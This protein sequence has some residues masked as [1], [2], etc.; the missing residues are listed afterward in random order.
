MMW[1]AETNWAGSLLTKI[2]K[3]L[4]EFEKVENVND[5][6]DWFPNRRKIK[7]IEFM[8][9]QKNLQVEFKVKKLKKP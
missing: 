6:L 2:W 7:V 3:G 4:K 5:D 1:L 8:E 9:E